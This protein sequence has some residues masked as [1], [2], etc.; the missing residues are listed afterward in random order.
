MKIGVCA[1][2][3]PDADARIK[4]AADGQGVVLDGVKFGISDY[5]EY[6]IEEAIRTKEKHG[7]EIVSFTV[8]DSS[9]DKQ[10]R[11]G[12]LALGV[13]RSVLVTDSAADPLGI[14]KLLAAAIAKESPELVFTGKSTIDDQNFQVGTMIAELLGWAH[15]TQV[16]A[17]EIEGS[18]FKATRNMDAGVRQVVSGTL[19]AVI[20]CEDGLNTVRYA[21]LPDIMKAKKKPLDSVSGVADTGA[22]RSAVGN[23]A[24]P[25]ERPA[26]RIIEGDAVTA[27]KE[28]VRLLRDEAKV[29]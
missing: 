27:S 3:T 9:A 12:A 16:T 8:G 7:G 29:I 18:A 25:P 1:K 11:S 13:D 14:A 10:L 4:V 17:L 28:L 26:G 23:L 21:K 19:P 20:S 22:A 6:A 15:V 5:D 2:I 24:P